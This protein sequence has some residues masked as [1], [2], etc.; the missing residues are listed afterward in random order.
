M[1]YNR[2]RLLKKPSETYVMFVAANRWPPSNTADHTHSRSWNSWSAVTYDISTDRYG[3]NGSP[4]F[5][6]GSSNYLFAD[7]HVEETRAPELKE[8]ID[9]GVNFSRPP[10]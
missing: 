9:D 7:N 1:N 10:D 6:D 3:E 4:E 2:R 5:L 8:M